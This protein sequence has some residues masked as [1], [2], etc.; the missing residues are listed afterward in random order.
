M[1][2]R[3]F[4]KLLGLGA[5]VKTACQKVWAF[6]FLTDRKCNVGPVPCEDN[7][8]NN[9]KVKK[10]EVYSMGGP[11]WNFE[12]YSYPTRTFMINHLQ[13]DHGVSI[14]MSIF[15]NREL[16]IIHN[17]IHNGYSN[18]GRA[19]TRTSSTYRRRGF[20]GRRR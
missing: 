19:R 9:D 17:N 12:G 7:V 13:E 11:N 16:R 6:P 1:N 4:L 3:M 2:K 20:F 5:A 8:D 18:L 15:T 10:P 14:D